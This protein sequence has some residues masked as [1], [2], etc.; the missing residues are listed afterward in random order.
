MAAKL[1]EYLATTRLGERGTMTLPKEYRDALKLETG[2]P[3]TILRVG[4]GLILMP[5]QQRFE[6]LC[7]SIAARLENAGV[8]ET[9][10]QATLP[11]VREQLARRRYPELFAGKGRQS[12]GRTRVPKVKGRKRK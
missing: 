11:E 4:D 5:E 7:E 1:I 6:Q 8:T 2:A 9:A 12:P 10:L 3:L